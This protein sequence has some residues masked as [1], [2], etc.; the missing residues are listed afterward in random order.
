MIPKS[1][2]CLIFSLMVVLLLGCNEEVVK[3]DTEILP[4]EQHA[5]VDEIF[6]TLTDQEQYYQHLLIEIPAVY[7]T[8]MDS[9]GDWILS[10]QPG[11]LCFTDWEDE[12]VPAP[13]AC[14][15]PRLH[16]CWSAPFAGADPPPWRLRSTLR[17]VLRCNPR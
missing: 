1:N 4:T 15:T 13:R 7:Q 17:G 9:L 16:R 3:N 14:R 11:G 12:H 2:I 5:V 8:N 6:G 10:V